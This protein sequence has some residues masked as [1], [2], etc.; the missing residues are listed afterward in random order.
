[1]TDSSAFDAAPATASAP[2]TGARKSPLF[3]SYRRRDTQG[4]TGRLYDS[5]VRVYGEKALFRDIATI[6]PGDKFAAAIEQALANAAV[7]IVVIGP[8]WVEMLNR[9]GSKSADGSIDYVRLEVETALRLG[10]PIV[11]LLVDGAAVPVKAELVETLRPLVDLNVYEASDKDWEY[12]VKLLCVTLDK[13]LKPP[14]PPWP[15][16]D[17]RLLVPAAMVGLSLYALAVWWPTQTASPSELVPRISIAELVPVAGRLD[18]GLALLV[19]AALAGAW[20]LMLSRMQSAAVNHVD[21]WLQD[22]RVLMASGIALVG[23][24]PPLLVGRPLFAGT[25]VALGLGLAAARQPLARLLSN[26]ARAAIA[27]VAMLAAPA[28]ALSADIWFDH[29]R[30]A[31]YDVAF[32]LPPEGGG[33]NE[34]TLQVFLEF[35]KALSLALAGMPVDIVPPRLDPLEVEQLQLQTPQKLLEYKGPRGAARVFIRV[36]YELGADRQPAKIGVWPYL[37]PPRSAMRLEQADD[38]QPPPFVGPAPAATL[39]L[40][41]GF[42]LIA[43]LSQRSQL[44]LGSKQQTQVWRQILQEYEQVLRLNSSD[45]SALADRVRL[46]HRAPDTLAVTQVRR[47]LFEPCA[48]PVPSEPDVQARTAGALWSATVGP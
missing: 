33:K 1:M 21:R 18:G 29:R 12:H 5:L 2:P 13:Y 10:K 34:E 6:A 28:L 42:E 30:Q 15:Q 38:W 47:T 40:R 27:L 39:A 9:F 22:G 26:T 16:I 14:A 45:C 17:R 19:V 25:V 46:M 4:V 11:P 35:R 23:G 48:V 32:L 8:R 44:R 3:I 37:R 7:V 24:V 43:Y 36:R 31:D 20:R 41:A